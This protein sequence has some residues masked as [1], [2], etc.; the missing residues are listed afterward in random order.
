MMAS[1]RC[2]KA[3]TSDGKRPSLEARLASGDDASHAR[4]DGAREAI[5][6]ELA[7]DRATYL[8][9]IRNRV[10]SGADAEDILQQALVKATERATDLRAPERTRA[11]FFQILRR[12]LADHLARWAVREA[13]LDELSVELA[14][15]T[16]E[17]VATCACSLGLLAQLRPEYAEML[18]RIDI[19]DEPLPAAAAAMG[20]TT[21]NA[22]VRLHRARKALREKLQDLCGTQSLR[23]CLDCSCG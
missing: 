11:W 16:P 21:N 20:I 1:V 18:R 4:V 23:A 6:R 8:A 10:R 12:T 2:A 14:E 5:A 15:A 9:F 3:E 7:A 22:T 17:E 13:K 19:D